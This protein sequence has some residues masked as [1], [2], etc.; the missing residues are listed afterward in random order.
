MKF[1]NLERSKANIYLIVKAYIYPFIITDITPPF[2]TV[3]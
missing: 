1:P 3:N 2:I